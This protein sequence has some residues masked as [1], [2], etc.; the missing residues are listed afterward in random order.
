MN[1]ST[2]PIVDPSY[3]AIT[4]TL[5]CEAEKSWGRWSLP[6]ETSNAEGVPVCADGRPLN[7]QVATPH[8]FPIPSR[9]TIKFDNYTPDPSK[10]PIPSNC[11]GNVMR[12]L[13]TIGMF[14]R[15]PDNKKREAVDATYMMRIC[16]KNEPIK[17]YCET[18][19]NKL[20]DY[21]IDV[22]RASSMGI[23]F[24]GDGGINYGQCGTDFGPRAFMKNQYDNYVKDKCVVHNSD[25]DG[26]CI[27]YGRFERKYNKMIHT[28][29]IL[30]T[31]GYCETS[32]P[33][34]DMLTNCKDMFTRT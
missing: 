26:N 22:A 14:C 20:K 10:I 13:R 7:T 27:G 11:E 25:G 4:T 24:C 3:P 2:V 23:Y 5:A 9:E 17:M 29:P 12:D 19:D 16:E 1:L 31:N 32:D 33:A 34:N 15:T 8:N 30:Y 18:S 6:Y 28:I 21:T